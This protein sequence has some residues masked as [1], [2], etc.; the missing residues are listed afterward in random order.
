MTIG[1]LSDKLLLRIFRCF[2]DS[3]PPSW[4]ILVHTCR[5]WRHLLFAFRR[6]LHLRLFCTHGTPVLKALYFQ[7]ALPIVVKYG[8]YSALNPPAPEDE[9]NIL[10]TLRRSDRVSS[11]YLTLTKSLLNKLSSI[12]GKFAVL[13]DLVLLSQD[14]SHL[15]LPS[16]FQSGTRLRVLHLTRV[17]FS[18]P[19]RLLSSS[20]DLVDIQLHDIS[21]YRYLS[22]TEL[23]GALSGMTHL[24]SLSLH[25][26]STTANQT[27]KLPLSEKSAVNRAVMNSLS[28]LKYRG[29]SKYLDNLLERVDASC[30][31]DLEIAFFDHPPFNISN[32][33]EFISRTEMLKLNRQAEILFSER[34]ISISLTQ[35]C[36]TFPVLCESPV[37]QPLLSMAEICSRLSA[38]HVMEEIRI[39]VVPSSWLYTTDCENWVNLFNGL[40]WFHIAGNSNPFMEIMRPL[41]SLPALLKLCICEHGSRFPPLREA[42]VSLMVDR[43]PFG[44]PMEAE[45][46]QLCTDEPTEVKTSKSHAQYQRHALTL[47]FVRTFLSA[48]DDRRSP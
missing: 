16:K 44:C 25:F 8:G 20:R 27:T 2:L 32:L 26:L 1:K 39:K 6:A 46:Q 10:A 22:P 40:K 36:L 3:S 15:V 17:A 23:A 11:I 29:T 43:R 14:D 45:Y 34:S 24:R 28:C 31:A 35:M 38:L 9:G 41:W 30:L 19:L 13:E 33:D 47:A 48:S 21:D 18:A 7:P 5:K 12:R 42:V 37:P 4:P